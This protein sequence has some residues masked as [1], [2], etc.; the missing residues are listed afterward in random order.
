MK[1][2]RGTLT[3][4]V[5][6]LAT[7]LLGREISVRELRLM[8]YFIYLGMDGSIIARD[9]LFEGDREVIDTW[10]KE[11]RVDCKVGDVPKISHEFWS[12]MAKIVYKSYV[13]N[14]EGE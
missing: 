1:K 6:E 3:S 5:Q 11:C 13:L 4:E 7:A 9:K 2:N 14:L 8:P 10:N 12:I